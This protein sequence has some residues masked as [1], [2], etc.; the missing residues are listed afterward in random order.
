MAKRG[1]DKEASR[2]RAQ[3]LSTARG[4]PGLLYEIALE[5]ARMLARF[6]RVPGKASPGV[7][8]NRRRGI[9]MDILTMLREAVADGFKDAKVLGAE[10]A[11]SPLR[12]TREY[13]AILLDVEFPRDPFARR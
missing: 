1:E 8:E 6:D 12:G 3:S 4:E 9:V 10:P 13:Q 2:W 5:D 7:R 11:F